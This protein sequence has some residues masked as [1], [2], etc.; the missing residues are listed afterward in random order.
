MGR[1]FKEFNDEKWAQVR[2]HEF[3]APWRKA[4][5]EKAEVYLSTE[6]PRVKFSIMHE[7]ETTG[8]RTHFER[9]YNDY[10]ARLHNYYNAYLLT[11]DEKYL[12]PLADII[13]NICNFESWSIPA[14]VREYL[15]VEQ[16]RQNLD[17]TSTL[18]GFQL[19]EILYFIGDKLPELVVRRAK[20]EIRYRIIDSYRDSDAKRYWWINSTNNWSAV[21]ICGVLGTYLYSC[22]KHEIDAQLPRMIHS[23]NCYLDGFAEDGC[24]LEGY[25]YWNYGFSYFCIFA[26]ML[27]EYTD[28]KINMFE[29]PK[30]QRIARFQESIPLNEREC[31]SFSDCGHIFQPMTWLSH[32][33]KGVYPDLRIPKLTCHANPT[34][35]LRSV[36]WM[37]PAKAVSSLNATEPV[38]FTFDDAQWFIYRSENYS[39]ACKAGSNN[40]PHNHNDIGSFLISKDGFTF[41]DPGGGEYTRQY[42]SGERYTIMLCSSRGHSVPIING[43]YQVTGNRKSKVLV[44]EKDRYAFTMQNGY[45]IESLESLTRDFKM[46]ES[47]IT[48]TD[49]YAFTEKPESVTERF[50]SF[51]PF[52]L[53]EGIVKCGASTLE[54]DATLFDATMGSE[55]VSLSGGKPGTVYF[56]D[57][58]VKSPEKNMTFTF[59]FA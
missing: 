49:S 13:W 12:E 41:T 34:S 33:L 46:S 20:A 59:T 50:V 11:L 10:G 28:G 44:N 32:Y 17:L 2:E 27:C 55:D 21:C 15:T 31:V 23:A 35:D 5:L 24:C 26:D 37:D 38:T 51:L 19:S 39:F 4:V 47:S 42:F 25:G 52:E 30:V 29:I 36:L 3:Y 54:Y 8:N 14:H 16:R 57:L 53:E 18:L 56:V 1:I 9:I 7:Y 6:P 48:M 45:N 58:A 40:E 43:E 22:E